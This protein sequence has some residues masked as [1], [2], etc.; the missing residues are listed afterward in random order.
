MSLV[1]NYVLTWPIVGDE[2]ERR[3]SPEGPGCEALDQLN[4]ALPY[5]HQTRG[6]RLT[7]DYDEPTGGTKWIEHNVAVAGMNYLDPEQLMEAMDKVTGWRKE[8]VRL[9]VC[10]QD[11][12][13]FSPVNWQGRARSPLEEL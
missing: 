8:D 4:A 5:Y 9:F 13:H 10:E 6:F 2:C 3:D 11:D 1:T 7:S 12:D